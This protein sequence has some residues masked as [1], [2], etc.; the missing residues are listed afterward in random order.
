[1]CAS[2]DCRE[3]NYKLYI[4]YVLSSNWPKFPSLYLMDP[5]QKWLPLKY[6]FVCVQNSLT[7]L[8]RD[9]KLFTIFVSKTK[10]VRL[11]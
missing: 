5:M 6:S 8:V 11:I 4:H 10:L 9:N 1:M 7:N 3:R 2:L